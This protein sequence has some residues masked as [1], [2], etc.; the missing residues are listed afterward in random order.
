MKKK[1]YLLLALL[2]LIGCRSKKSSL[3]E[4]REE[5]KSERKETKDSS[6]QV[7][8]S[9][10]VATFDLQHSQSY[11]LTLEG[12]K[13]SIGH[14]KEVV[15]YRIRDGDSETIRVINGRVILKTIDTHSKSLQQADSTLTITT[16]TK[17]Q[18]ILKTQ[19]ARREVQKDKEVKVNSYTWIFFCVLFIIVLF[20][21]SR[22]AL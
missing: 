1:L 16:N 7:E 3:T 9:Q 12:D 5:Q 15:Y 17:E 22:K 18:S 4:H 13:D 2:L 20:F 10:K 21:L 19:T 14:S 11:E 8:K 6:I